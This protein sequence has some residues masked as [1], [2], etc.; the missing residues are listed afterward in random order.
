MLFREEDEDEEMLPFQ[1]RAEAG[2]I[3]AGKLSAYADRSDVV[4]VGLI[5][6]GVAVASEV[7]R[8]LRAPLDVL[9]VRKLGVPWNEELAMGAIA[10]SGVRVLDLS[11]VRELSLSDSF[12][13]E[14][15]DAELLE[16]QRREQLYRGDRPPLS[17]AGKTVVLVDDGIATGCSIL[18]GIGALRRQQAARV[19]VA[20]PVAPMSACNVLRMEADEVVCLA[21][22]AS[23][24]AISQWYEDFGQISD[25]EVR[26]LLEQANKPMPSAA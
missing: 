24:L 23:F 22:P 3:L 10:A 21:E 26:T 7:A 16:L 11:L 8:S 13:Q 4:V 17:V 25:G 1:D 9:V 19:V 6:G 5:R 12:I 15:A 20:I 2:R 14:L 18:A